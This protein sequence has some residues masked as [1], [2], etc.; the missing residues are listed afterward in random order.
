[1]LDIIFDDIFGDND[2]QDA[3]L[4]NDMYE[5]STPDD[6]SQD[7]FLSF[8]SNDEDVLGAVDTTSTFYTD[9]DYAINL[10]SYEQSRDEQLLDDLSQETNSRTDAVDAINENDL[11]EDLNDSHFLDSKSSTDSFAFEEFHGISSNE[12]TDESHSE[13]SFKGQ[14]K[15]AKEWEDWYTKRA[16][17]AFDKERQ[18]YDAAAKAAERGDTSAAKSHSEIAK[19][20]H[21]KGI[22]NM[23]SANVWRG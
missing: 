12:T 4:D 17:D 2:L 21:N 20:W 13:I 1:M 11:S 22:D 10:D 15:S 14:S 23:R 5:S 16:N 18:E 6:V 19:S 3:T 7:N 8:E 9:E